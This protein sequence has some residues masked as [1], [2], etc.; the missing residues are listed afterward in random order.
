[1][2]SHKTISKRDEA[3]INNSACVAHLK[4]LQSSL[5][6]TSRMHPEYES[7]PNRTGL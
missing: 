7:T 3:E 6:S 2:D 5:I 1:M 4:R